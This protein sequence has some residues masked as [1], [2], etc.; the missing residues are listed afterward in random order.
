MSAPPATG[1]GSARAGLGALIDVTR[2]AVTA[3][4]DTVR[5]KCR[6]IAIRLWSPYDSDRAYVLRDVPVCFVRPPYYGCL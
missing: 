4:I 6:L 1:P 3:T 5:P 2:T